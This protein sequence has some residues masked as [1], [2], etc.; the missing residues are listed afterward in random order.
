MKLRSYQN[1][2]P[3]TKTWSKNKTVLSNKKKI[4]FK[5]LEMNDSLSTT[6]ILLE[7]IHFMQ[8]QYHESLTEF[9]K[10]VTLDP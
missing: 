1:R 8:K 2:R 9:E 5:S 6:Q 4:C 7:D 3:P 10:A